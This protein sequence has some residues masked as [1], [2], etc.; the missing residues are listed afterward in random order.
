MSY[1]LVDCN[2]FYVSCERLFRPDLEKKPVVVL[3]N[4]DGCIIARSEEVKAMGIGMAI[5]FYQVREYV[6]RRD[7]YAF[8]SNYALYGD[9][10]ARVMSVLEEMAPQ[11]E[12]Y[13]IDEAF[14][15]LQGMEAIKDLTDYGRKIRQRIKQ[16]VGIPVGVGIGPTKTLAKLANYAAKRYAAT[17]GVVDLHRPDWCRR[18]L[19]QV[20]VVEVWGVGRRSAEK[21]KAEN[22][23]TAA[24]LALSDPDVM[25]RR[26]SVVL[27]RTILE[28]RG[29]RCLTFDVETEAKQQV[30]C[31]RTFSSRITQLQP[32]QEAIREYAVRAAEKL[33]EEQ[34]LTQHVSVYIRTNP[35]APFEQ[36]YRNVASCR[37]PSPTNDSRVIMKKAVRLLDMIYK[38]NYRYMKAGVMLNDLQPETSYQTDLFT[39]NLHTEQSA[40]LMN[41]LDKVNQRYSGALKFAG[42]GREQAWAMQRNLLSPSYTTSW[43]AIRKVMA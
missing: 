9:I 29:V 36:K 16:W 41:V 22:I 5:P 27:A 30:L 31:S 40:Q 20:P 14:L 28:L 39:E 18:L 34:R 33:R 7:L 43:Q 1:A 13:S 2:C 23:H 4:N 3:S 38:P 19:P 11:V 42:Q 26:Y 15:D 6:D 37:L 35:N 25:G 10:S 8:S 12:V 17:G 21:L 32:M 24:D